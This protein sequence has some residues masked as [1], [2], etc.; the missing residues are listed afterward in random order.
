MKKES[1]EQLLADVAASYPF[2]E[3]AGH[4]TV[5]TF[6]TEIQGVG[7][8]SVLTLVDGPGGLLALS[9]VSFPEPFLNHRKFDKGMK[10]Y[11]KMMSKQVNFEL[12][13]MAPQLIVVSGVSQEGS[14]VEQVRD[15]LDATYQIANLGFAGM[16][17]WLDR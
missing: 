4:D 14:S 11:L 1:A 10:K 3:W 16:I 6:Q 5:Q 17:E 7:F 13:F 15:L 9:S 2:A 12:R 8:R